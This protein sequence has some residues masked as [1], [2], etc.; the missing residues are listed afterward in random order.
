MLQYHTHALCARN[1]K[2]TSV[3]EPGL[4]PGQVIIL[5][6]SRFFFIKITATWQWPRLDTTRPNSHVNAR[7]SHFFLCSNVEEY[8][9]TLSVVA[10]LYLTEKWLTYTQFSVC[11]LKSPRERMKGRKKNYWYFRLYHITQYI[12]EYPLKKSYLVWT[13][14]EVCI[15]DLWPEKPD[16]T[17]GAK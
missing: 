7:A 3:G 11:Y 10:S 13:R 12:Y 14:F 1:L 2:R 17:G 15:Q 16:M 9:V 6:P 8:F 4:N 5:C